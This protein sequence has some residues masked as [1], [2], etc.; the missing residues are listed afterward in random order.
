MGCTSWGSI[1]SRQE[2][3]I[4]LFFK[5][6][7]RTWGPPRLL[8]NGQRRV[9]TRSKATLMQG[10][11]KTSSYRRNVFAN[12]VSAGCFIFPG[13]YY[14]PDP[15]IPP[16]QVTTMYKSN[17]R[18]YKASYRVEHSSHRPCYSSYAC[19]QIF[20]PVTQSVGHLTLVK[21]SN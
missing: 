19:P 6:T 11:G 18:R 4:F 15:M 1:D 2:N 10:A 21:L 7:D 14:K 3:K 17:S 12:C 13:L 20:Q 16:T 5:F 9:C 8:F